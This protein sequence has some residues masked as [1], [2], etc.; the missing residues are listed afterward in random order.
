MMQR[1]SA[2]WKL[3]A[4]SAVTAIMLLPSST[5]AQDEDQNVVE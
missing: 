5:F 4:V 1:M 2:F 3:T